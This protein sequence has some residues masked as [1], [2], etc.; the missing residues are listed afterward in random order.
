M[1]TKCHL[2][3]MISE[4]VDY[5]YCLGTLVHLGTLLEDLELRVVIKKSTFVIC[6]RCLYEYFRGEPCFS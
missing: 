6:G 2:L 1:L 3:K 5:Q 4:L